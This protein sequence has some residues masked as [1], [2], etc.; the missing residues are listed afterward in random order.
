MTTQINYDQIAAHLDYA[1]V[2]TK[3]EQLRTQVPPKT[4]T[5]VADLLAPIIGKL[6]Q[7]RSKGWTYDQ[8]SKEL[9]AGGLPI[10]ASALR[11][12]LGARTKRHRK[13]ASPAA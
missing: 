10:K 1:K 12:H 7:L 13:R 8:L 9:N 3:L 4:Q 6:R 5:T 2:A 11:R